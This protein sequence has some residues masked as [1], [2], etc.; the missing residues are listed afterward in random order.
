MEK[1]FFRISARPT[2]KIDPSA[3]PEP[4]K[5]RF[6]F[7]IDIVHGLKGFGKADFVLTKAGGQDKQ[8]IWEAG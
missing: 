2:R 7:L 6:R 4:K 1:I 5:P 8:N 3:H